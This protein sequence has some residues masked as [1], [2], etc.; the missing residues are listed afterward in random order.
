M[1]PDIESPS[2]RQPRR[3][4]RGRRASAD[5]SSRHEHGPSPAVG[6][7]KTARSGR[8]AK[9]A[10]DRA[11]MEL[12]RRVV[13][14]RPEV[15][16]AEQRQLLGLSLPTNDTSTPNVPSASPI[17]ATPTF[18]KGKRARQKKKAAERTY[19]DDILLAD[20]EQADMGDRWIPDMEHRRRVTHR[21]RGVP[22]Q[23][24][25]SYCFLDDYMYRSSLTDEEIRSHPLLDDV[26][27]FQTGG[28]QPVTPPGFQWDGRKQLVPISRGNG[29]D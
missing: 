6:I 24:W 22:Y 9:K 28:P 19:V 23:L 14:M 27:S 3:A 17:A 1:K 12:E 20:G 16:L 26:Y 10:K 29:V 7:Q 8:S 11:R 5:E 13:A 25:M 15:A 21:P 2:R 4:A 18:S